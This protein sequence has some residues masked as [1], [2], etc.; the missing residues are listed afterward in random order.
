MM[1]RFS[2]TMN[3]TG[4]GPKVKDSCWWTG[5]KVESQKAVAIDMERIDDFKKKRIL[6]LFAY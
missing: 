1:L 6:G 4:K 5:V 3:P 2:S